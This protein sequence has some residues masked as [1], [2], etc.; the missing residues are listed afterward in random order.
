M[1]GKTEEEVIKA[2]KEK[3]NT[4]FCGI[5][6]LYSHDKL[7]KECLNIQQKRNDDEMF[8]GGSQL[9]IN[10]PKS[11]NSSLQGGSEVRQKTFRTLR[12]KLIQGEG[13][14]KQLG[15]PATEDGINYQ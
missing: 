1:Q 2:I 3:K 13:T 4:D 6:E 14:N 11:T 7:K 5:Y 12:H 15:H 9:D 10:S 8:G